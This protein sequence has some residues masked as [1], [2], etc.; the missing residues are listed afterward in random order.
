VSGPETSVTHRTGDR[1]YSLVPG[2]KTCY[3][4]VQYKAI[5]ISGVAK[6]AT[7]M[8]RWSVAESEFAPTSLLIPGVLL[9]LGSRPHRRT[10]RR[11]LA[12]HLVGPA[13]PCAECG[14]FGECL[15]TLCAL[16]TVPHCQG[17][18]S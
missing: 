16:S 1:C 10:S 15:I 13:C 11:P 8:G 18:C 3:P 17:L 7:P 12:A 14:P 9:D 2:A 5:P 4:C 6:R